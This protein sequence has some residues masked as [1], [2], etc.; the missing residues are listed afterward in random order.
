MKRVSTLFLIAALSLPG[1]AS[2]QSAAFVQSD[3][4]AYLRQLQLAGLVSLHPWTIRPFSYRELRRFSVADSG[5]P[6]P[7]RAFGMAAGGARPRLA[8]LPIEN[9]TSVNSSFPWGYNDGAVW[10][11]RGLTTVLR[12]GVL[13]T[14]GPLSL[15]LY[16]TAFATQNAGFTL[17]NNGRSDSLRFAHGFDPLR[18][19]VPQRFGNGAYSR[20][21]PGQS[22]VRIDLPVVTVGLSTANEW[23][24]PAVSQPLILGNN[25]GGFPHVFL[26]SSE[27]ID[28]WIGK[29]HGRMLWGDLRQSSFTRN[30]PDNRRFGSGIVGT[31]QPRGVN[32]LEIGGSRFFHEAWPPNGITW[33]NIARPLSAFARSA[34]IIDPTDPG[35]DPPNQIASLWMRWAVPSVG[36]EFYAEYAKDDDNWDL[37]DYIGEPENTGGYTL[38]IRK[39]WG[40]AQS[41]LWSAG[42]EH[43]DARQSQWTIGRPSGGVFYEHGPN[44]PQGHSYRGQLLGSAFG[45]RGGVATTATLDHYVPNGRLRLTWGRFLMQDARQEQLQVANRVRRVVAYDPEGYDVIQAL[46]AE[47]VRFHGR[48]TFSGGLTAMHEFNRYLLGDA[49]NL[50]AWVGASWAP[51]VTPPALRLARAARQP[52]L[53]RVTI[54]SSD[55]TTLDVSGPEAER[56]RLDQLLGQASTAGFLLRS[57]SSL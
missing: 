5:H 9:R 43:M 45:I 46:G 34:R 27:P 50:Y 4:E 13:G 41:E 32:G 14:W 40:G 3:E 12:G 37:R 29:I 52:T 36:V 10:Q 30:T 20:V 17:Q 48:M 23:W 53:L 55:F 15:T 42:I 28:I 57:P 8:V 56:E 26:G 35:S 31:F 21:D 2:A 25:A 44:L 33:A 19:D 24:G 6:W 51:S 54:D 47:I 11:G 18:V 1:V 7:G 38:G 39:T 22:T 49:T 16:P